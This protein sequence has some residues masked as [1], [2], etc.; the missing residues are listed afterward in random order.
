M[1][2]RLTKLVLS[3]EAFSSMEVVGRGVL[4][5]VVVEGAGLVVMEVQW[6]T[7]IFWLYLYLFSFVFVVQESGECGGGRS[8]SRVIGD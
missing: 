1:T 6:I 5:V 2:I 4:D 3:R 8:V 7:L